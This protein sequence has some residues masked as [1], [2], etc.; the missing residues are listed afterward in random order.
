M[1]SVYQNW[2]P[3]RVCA[4]GSFY[5]KQF[6]NFIE[7]PKARYVF[8]RISDEV[9]ED[10]DNFINFLKSRNINIIRTHIDSDLDRYIIDDKYIP[11]PLTPRD[12]T[13]MIG[14]IFFTE[15]PNRNKIWNRLKGSSWP[16]EPPKNTVEFNNLPKNIFTELTEIYNIQNV[17][18]LYIRDYSSLMPLVNEVSS[19]DNKIVY[20]EKIDS[21]MTF[22]VGK[23]LYFGTWPNQDHK[24]LQE[25]MELMF[26]NNRCHLIDSQGHLD[27]TISIIKPGL[28]FVRPDF[29]IDTLKKNFPGWEIY[30]AR[31]EATWQ[32][33]KFKKLKLK[34]KGKWWVPGEESNDE[35]TSFV[36]T[37]IQNWVGYCEETVFSVNLLML[38]QNNVVCE[39]EDNNAFKVFQ[40][41]NITP[42]VFKFRHC[43][44]FDSGWHCLTSDLHR[45]GRMQ[46]FF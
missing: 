46:D 17:F 6:F 23:D 35:F 13:G 11:A 25:K 2:D 36:E 15:S 10:L 26:P 3:L 22:R 1:Y 38:D 37:Y 40:R 27:G 28:I 41:H 32:G 45:E 24:K 5:P 9:N 7:H 43:N 42:H 19:Q 30:P 12:D 20:D 16:D 44:F 14:D 34:N 21:A 39:K 18:D 4:V 31:T 33:P 29:P 8:E